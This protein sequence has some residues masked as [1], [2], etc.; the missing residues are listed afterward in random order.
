MRGRCDGRGGGQPLGHAASN[1]SSASTDSCPGNERARGGRSSDPS[2]RTLPVSPPTEREM[3]QVDSNNEDHAEACAAKEQSKRAFAQQL[4]TYRRK[5]EKQLREILK[6]PSQSARQAV[7]AA[8]EWNR[9][10]G[11]RVH[12]KMDADALRDA[13]AVLC[14][15][16]NEDLSGANA[17]KWLWNR[18]DG[19]NFEPRGLGRMAIARVAEIVSR[20][21]RKL[22]EQLELL[23][24][25]SGGTGGPS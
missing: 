21:K 12:G 17:E 14:V 23:M 11:F 18:A 22:E 16:G 24:G 3:E 15:A 25:R 2:D 6:H 13:E 5:T 10:A 20:R 4:K 8:Q 19:V 7:M 1:N 9:R